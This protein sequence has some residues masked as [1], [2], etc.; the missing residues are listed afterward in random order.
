MNYSLARC[1][2]EQTDTQ[3]VAR[4][5]RRDFLKAAAGGAAR[6]SLS[7]AGQAVPPSRQFHPG[8]V[9]LDTD[10]KPIQ[11]HGGGILYHEGIFYWYGEDKTLG[12]NNKVGASCYSSRDLFQWKHEGTALAAA[13]VPEQFRDTGV[14]ER[15]KVIYNA[16]THKFVLW[17]HLDAH[18]YSES[19]AGVAISDSPTGPFVLLSHTHPIGSSTYRDMN[20][21]LDTDGQAYSIYS[22][23][24]NAT[25][26]IVRLNED[27][28]GPE[29]PTVEGKT[30]VRAIVRHSREAPAPFKHENRY[31]LLTSGTSGW[32]PN[33]AQVATADHILG[34]WTT[35]DNPCV[36]PGADKTFRSQSTFVLPITG[37]SPGGFIYMGDRWEPKN[38]AD[39]RYIWLPFQ[40]KPDGSFDLHW[41]DAWDLSVFGHRI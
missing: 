33:A 14:L 19:V 38:L 16:K 6:L 17:A 12:Y 20:L 36:G 7:Q 3:K 41:Q 21:F 8:A 39:S 10:G 34:P 37:R 27:F 4:M 23:E 28:T 40:I 25:I 9:W 29:T 26:Y 32:D 2:W 22:A 11:A 1:V 5:Q 13:A 15:P 18:G 30:W 35:G 31:Y 24:D